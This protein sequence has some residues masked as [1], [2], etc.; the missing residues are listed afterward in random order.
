MTAHGALALP[1]IWVERWG[2]WDPKAA[3]PNALF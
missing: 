3:I 1:H 2:S